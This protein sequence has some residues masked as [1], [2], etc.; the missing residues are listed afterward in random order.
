MNEIKSREE[1]GPNMLRL[2]LMLTK[3]RIK[4]VCLNYDITYP[5]VVEQYSKDPIRFLS[6]LTSRHINRMDVL[7]YLEEKYGILEIPVMSVEI[8]LPDEL[9]GE[10]GRVKLICGLTREMVE[11]LAV[12]FAY[13][14]HVLMSQIVNDQS[15]L[16]DAIRRAT[17]TRRN[18]LEPR[19][20]NYDLPCRVLY[21][22]GFFRV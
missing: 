20:E 21:N 13:K 7:A 19:Q 11:I 3:K 1:N 10:N 16:W 17:D 8:D 22:L 14:S 18:V 6:G 15:K 9:R 2:Y 4:E 5:N 12:Y